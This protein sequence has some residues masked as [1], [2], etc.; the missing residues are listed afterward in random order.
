[1]GKKKVFRGVQQRWSGDN[2]RA[3]VKN[4]WKLW[5]LYALGDGSTLLR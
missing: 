2:L 3:G 4:K 5:E 1:M